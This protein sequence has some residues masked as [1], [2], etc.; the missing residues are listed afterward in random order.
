MTIVARWKRNNFDFR[1]RPRGNF[2][3]RKITPEI[4]RQLVNPKLLIEWAPYSLLQRCIKFEEL[5][6]FK[7]STH[8][9]RRYYKLN[10]VSYINPQYSYLRK[11]NQQEELTKK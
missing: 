6:G 1:K 4:E 5:F 2:L 3:C 8:T 11:L 10:K 9:I 7:I